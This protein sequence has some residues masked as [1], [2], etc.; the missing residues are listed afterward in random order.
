MHLKL[1]SN[2]LNSPQ[3]KLTLNAMLIFQIKVNVEVNISNLYM[4]TVQKMVGCGL[5][6]GEEARTPHLYLYRTPLTPTGW[7][8]PLYPAYEKSSEDGW[9]Q[10]FLW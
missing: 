1:T 3:C 5:F 4:K 2:Y 7:L 9:V 6:C 8:Q 10:I